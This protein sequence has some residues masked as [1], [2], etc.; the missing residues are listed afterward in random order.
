M[1]IQHWVYMSSPQELE[2]HKQLKTAQEKYI[3]FLLAAAA[4]A[5]GFAIT[6]TKTE[7]LTMS[8]IPLGIA[9][10]S[11][12]LSFYSGLKIIGFQNDYIVNNILYLQ[13]NDELQKFPR[14]VETLEFASQDKQRLIKDSDSRNKKLVIYNFLQK[15]SLLVGSCFYIFSHILKM[16]NISQMII[17][18]V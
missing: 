5:I 17:V 15:W 16:Y 18:V 1:S 8:H 6:Q 3:Y 9:V 2:L 12:V 14:T 7:A 4:S 13:K 11:W 10:F